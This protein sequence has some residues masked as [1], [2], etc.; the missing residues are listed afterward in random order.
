MF[1][2]KSIKLFIKFTLGAL[3]FSWLFYSLFIQIS[4]QSNLK[5]TIVDIFTT[6]SGFKISFLILV[7][8]LMI[9]NWSIEA[10]KWKFLLKNTEEISFSKALQSTLTGV[11]VSIITPNRIGEYFGRI[12]YLKN[13]NKIKGI[14]ITI[15]GSFAQ[16]LV[17]GAFGVIGLCFYMLTITNNWWLV[18]VLIVSILITCFL[19]Y[20]IFNLKKFINWIEKIP[21]LRRLKIYIEVVSRFDKTI[22]NK[23]ILLSILRYF[24]Y[25]IQFYLLLC[26]TH[27][28]LFSLS[29]LP[30]INLIFW[31]MA[32]LPSVAI[33]DLG[34]RGEAA[35]YFLAAFST[36]AIAILLTSTMLWFI[37]LILPAMIGCFFVFKMKLFDDDDE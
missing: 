26:I 16:F 3:L 37:N 28:E 21:Y 25:T 4:K 18:V 13:K 36:N 23:I 2:N 11:A 17:T 24:I 6:W 33:A 8:I 27:N 1:K 20:F 7:F 14:S 12:L 29:T 15:T 32:I 5:E 9:F 19:T 22:L 34:I 10:L 31:A 30:I 35:I